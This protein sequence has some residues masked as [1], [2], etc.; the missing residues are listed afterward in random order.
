[1]S[2]LVVSPFKARATRIFSCEAVPY[3][4]GRIFTRQSP[5][6]QKGI[7]IHLSLYPVTVPTPIKFGKGSN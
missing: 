4:F 2:E 6:I 1:M 5:Q 3:R 7:F